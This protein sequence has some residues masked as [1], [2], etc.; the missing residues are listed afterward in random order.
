VAVDFYGDLCPFLHF[1]HQP[2]KGRRIGRAPRIH[3]GNVIRFPLFGDRDDDVP[4][5]IQAGPAA[6]HEEIGN[7]QAV[8]MAEFYQ[9]DNFLRSFAP[10]APDAFDDRV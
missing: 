9:L 6:L 8:L 7:F 2:G 5:Q 1:G 10:V 4:Q 3:N